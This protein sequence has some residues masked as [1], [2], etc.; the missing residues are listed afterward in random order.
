VTA[1]RFAR[2][3]WPRFELGS[4]EATSSADTRRAARRWGQP[5]PYAR[6][7][8]GLLARLDRSPER[9]PPRRRET[10]ALTVARSSASFRRRKKNRR[11]A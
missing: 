2:A 11:E 8:N 3:V 6:T 4:E 7:R 10:V 9:M 1:S 5:P